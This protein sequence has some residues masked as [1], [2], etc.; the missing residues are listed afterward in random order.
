MRL[1]LSLHSK[2]AI[3]RRDNG[4]AA[5]VSTGQSAKLINDAVEFTVGHK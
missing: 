5:F 1:V 3:S 4:Q 2:H